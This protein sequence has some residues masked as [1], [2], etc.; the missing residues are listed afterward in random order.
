[1][2]T[3]QDVLAAAGYYVGNGGYY[4]K[5]D[6]TAKYLTRDTANFAANKGSANYSYFGKI[7][8]INPGAW[9]A[10]FVSVC[11]M[12]AAGSKEAAKKALWGVWPYANCGQLWDAAPSGAKRWSWYQRN[13]K[14]RSGSSYTPKIGDVI[15]FSDNGTSRDHTGIVYAV[16]GSNVYTHEGNSGNM[17]RK[18]S[19]S[20]KSS[21]IYGYVTL[22]MEAGSV[23]EIQKFQKWLGVSADGE[24]G[25]KTKA[26]AVLAHQMELNKAYDAGIEEDGEW[27]PETYYATQN[28]QQGDEGNDVTVLQG[29]LY[30]NGADPNGIDGEFGKNTLTA[31]SKFQAAKSLNATGIADRYTWAKLFGA[32]KP[33]HTTLKQGSAGAEVKYLQR[34]LSN[35]GYTAATDGEFGPQTELAVKSFQAEKGLTAD[36]IVGEKTWAALD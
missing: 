30:C 32:T 5:R 23:S 15:V 19:Y 2:G 28:V 25:P 18:R 11:V 31:V 3:L 1:M 34:R 6:G 13:Y 9:C 22:N 20:L 26:A 27:G 16:D 14:G 35:A 29:M 21:Y 33:K 36:G 4:E 7:C 8:G 24:Y 12:E 10:M 17:A